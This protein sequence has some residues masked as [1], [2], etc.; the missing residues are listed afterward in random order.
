LKNTF[1]KSSWEKA[2]TINISRNGKANNQQQAD[3]AAA[4]GTDRI[5]KTRFDKNSN[6]HQGVEWESVLARL[7]SK[8]GRLWSLYQ[9]E[10]TGGEPDVV[11]CNPPTGVLTFIDCS[12]ESPAGRRS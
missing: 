2:W 10:A 11:D 8:P 9:M 5:L 4:A 12:A 3:H 6:C 7:E 1:Q